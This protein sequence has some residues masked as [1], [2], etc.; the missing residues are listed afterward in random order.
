MKPQTRN[1]ARER[2]IEKA[3]DSWSHLLY[4]RLE[5]FDHFLEAVQADLSAA[6]LPYSKSGQFLTDRIVEMNELI[7]KEKSNKAV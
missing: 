5:A 1:R 4:S 6:G 3:W 2:D 7:Q